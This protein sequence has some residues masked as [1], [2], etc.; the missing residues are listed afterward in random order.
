MALMLLSGL[1]FLVAAGG[2]WPWSFP[3][4]QHQA[5]SWSIL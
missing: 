1:Q 5:R 2:L 4:L 3:D